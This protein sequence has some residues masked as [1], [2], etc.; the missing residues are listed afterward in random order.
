MAIKRG[1]KAVVHHKLCESANQDINNGNNQ[2]FVKW[3]KNTKSRFK[4]IVKL[5]DKKGALPTFL[6]T[7]EKHHYSLI[8]ISYDIYKNTFSPLCEVLVESD[9]SDSRA[10][11]EIIKRKFTITE[12]SSL[13]DAYK[14]T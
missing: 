14:G 7:L 1:Q 11:H 8:G 5:E 4:I 6:S 9:N 10:L 3:T 13:K 2:L 12:V